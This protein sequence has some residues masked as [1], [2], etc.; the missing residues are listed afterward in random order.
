MILDVDAGNTCLKWVLHD[1]DVCRERALGRVARREVASW[2]SELDAK[3]LSRIRL[4]SVAG[5]VTEAFSSWAVARGVTLQLATVE[6]G[7]G[8]V[9]CGYREPSR[10]GVDRWL[11]VLAV[12]ERCPEAF[13]VVDAGTAL[14]VDV[15]DERGHHLGGYIAPGL[16]MMADSLVANTWGVR[17]DGG[18]EPSMRPGVVTVEAVMHGCLASAVGLVEAVVVRQAVTALFLTGGDAEILRDNIQSQGRGGR[19]R[20]SLDPQLVLAGLAIALP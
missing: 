16:A 14:T 3:S 19:L 8:G 11:A 4:A 18:T 5:D 10:L 9:F 13:V 17:T 15:V 6:D 2:L 1:G 20:V 12:R 7:A